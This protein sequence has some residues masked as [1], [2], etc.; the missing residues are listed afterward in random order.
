MKAFDMYRKGKI[1]PPENPI[2]VC[3]ACDL[4]DD[5]DKL[6]EDEEEAAELSE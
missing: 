2:F 6:D 5:E 3:E 1:D 4:I